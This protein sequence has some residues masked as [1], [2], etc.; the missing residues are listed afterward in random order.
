MSLEFWATAAAVGTF[1]VIAATA[2]AALVQLR[3]LRSNNLIA[4]AL[5]INQVTEG[6]EFQ[7]ARRFLREDMVERLKEIDYRRELASSG[8]LGRQAQFVG[9]YYELIGIFVKNGLIDENL[10][11]EMWSNE[12]IADWELLAP[13]VAIAMRTRKPSGW[14]N[15]AY[16]FAVCQ[17]WQARF[18]DGKFSGNRQ[19]AQPDDVWLAEDEAAATRKRENLS[20]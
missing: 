15:F 13:A 1:L 18:P 14:E 19:P 10:A 2:V 12:I 4:A 17:Q 6:D 11:C 16:M 20:S 7:A 8:K 5:A 3:H 9:N